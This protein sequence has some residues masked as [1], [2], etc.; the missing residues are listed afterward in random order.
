MNP[1]LAPAVSHTANPWL[2]PTAISAYVSAAASSIASGIA[3]ASLRISTRER[4]KREQ[5]EQRRE[6]EQRQAQASKVVLYP[7]MGNGQR[8]QIVVTNA[9]DLPIY[10]VTVVSLYNNSGIVDRVAQVL[11]P[12]GETAIAAGGVVLPYESRTVLTFLDAAYDPW[13]RTAAGRLERGSYIHPADGKLV[14]W[15]R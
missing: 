1:W 2:A 14:P 8:A 11:P 3:V 13:H 7:R 4:R 6:E 10:D 9:S 5:E 12:Q 15:Q